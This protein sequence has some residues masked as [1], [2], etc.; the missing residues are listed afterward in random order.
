M[1]RGRLRFVTA[2]W[3]LVLMAGCSHSGLDEGPAVDLSPVVE[4]DSVVPVRR[5]EITESLELVGTLYPWRFASIVSEV[6]GVIERLPMCEGELAVEVEG[7]KFSMEIP[8]DIGHEVQEDSILVEIDR[9]PFQLA[10]DAAQAQLDVATRELERLKAWKRDEEVSQLEAQAREAEARLRQA[11]LDLERYRELERSGTKA[12]SASERDAA[13]ATYETALAAKQRAEAAL[14]LARAGPTPEEV[15]VAEAQVKLAAA[16]VALKRDQLDKCTI[17]SPYDAV[18][19]DRYVGVGDRVTAMPRVEIMQIIDPSLLLAQVN[20]PEKYYR[21]VKVNDLAQV[22]ARGLAEPVPGLVALVNEKIDPETRTFRVRV[23]VENP[24]R[25]P[26]SASSE[27]IFKAG[28]Y[29]RVILDLR[30]AFEALIVPADAVTFD[31]GQPAV[32]VF[33][34]D[35]VEKRSVEL[36]ISS[37]TEYE[38]TAGVSEG[39]KVVQG[40]T[41]LLADGLPVRL[42][43]TE[44]SPDGSNAGKTATVEQRIERSAAGLSLAS[45][46]GGARP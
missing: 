5:G 26:D 46:P 40:G 31:K 24:K 18:I 3:I 41:A 29:V 36:G 44:P 17:Y 4:I 19:V 39:E 27:R 10:L 6:D 45:E 11:Q 43:G 7:R 23:G 12:A 8:L 33:H 37:E 22:E 34:G 9:R 15:Q 21:L 2:A 20:V 16:D 35:K 42:K 28:S 30:S 25:N 32:F 13:Q 38:V 14:E 1:T